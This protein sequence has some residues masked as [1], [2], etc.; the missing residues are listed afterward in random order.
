MQTV[1]PSPAVLP[2]LPHAV[3]AVS[4]ESLAT[5]FSGHRAHS[6]VALSFA[7]RPGGHAIQATEP[8]SWA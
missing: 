2:P 1:L 7:A 8:S 5:V 6:T 4:P 3:H